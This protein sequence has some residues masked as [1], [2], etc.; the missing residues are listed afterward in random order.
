MLCQ[1]PKHLV[2]YVIAIENDVISAIHPTLK[3]QLRKNFKE[4]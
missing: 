1:M 3:G 2:G 4:R